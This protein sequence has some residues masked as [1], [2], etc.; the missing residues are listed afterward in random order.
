MG[1]KTNIIIHKQH[2]GHKREQIFR[3]G[4]LGKTKQTQ[5]SRFTTHEH[6][7]PLLTMDI[8][9]ESLKLKGK[10]A[11]VSVDKNLIWRGSEAT[12][13]EIETIWRDL[14]ARSYTWKGIR[15]RLL[16]I[17]ELAGNG[18]AFPPVFDINYSGISFQ[19]IDCE[20]E[21]FVS[22]DDGGKIES[23]RNVFMKE[24]AERIRTL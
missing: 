19:I 22:S 10:K 4:Y 21:I 2:P 14:T 24:R 13:T 18:I 1:D 11:T 9:I 16:R 23:L 12:K 5:F 3:I 8:M 15:S 17:I 20:D 7:E 6:L